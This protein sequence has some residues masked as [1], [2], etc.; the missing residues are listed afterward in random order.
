[1]NNNVIKYSPK[2]NNLVYNA[3]SLLNVGGYYLMM[4]YIAD[5][6]F[7][8]HNFLILYKMYVL[9]SG[10]ILCFCLY[11]LTVLTM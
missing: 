5:S 7:T 1:M 8:F 2:S 6:H 11:I 4:L 9:D 3:C 10:E